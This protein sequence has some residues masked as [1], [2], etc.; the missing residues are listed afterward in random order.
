MATTKKLTTNGDANAWTAQEASAWAKIPYRALLRM[1]K[2]G[3]AP[4]L[5]LGDPQEQRMGRGRK[6][7]RRACGRFLVPKTAFVH[8]YESIQPAGRAASRKRVA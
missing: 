1:F 2:N 3:E 5:W 8:W 6:K 4:C 7:R